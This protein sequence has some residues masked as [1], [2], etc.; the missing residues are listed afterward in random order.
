MPAGTAAS[1]GISSA[2]RLQAARGYSAWASARALRSAFVHFLPN[3]VS[4][5]SLHN[6][7]FFTVLYFSK[8]QVLNR[9]GGAAFKASGALLN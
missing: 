1:A 5:L 6:D 8:A 7:K 3:D 2:I 9:L 4:E